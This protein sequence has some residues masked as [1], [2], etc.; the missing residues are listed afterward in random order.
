MDEIRRVI[1]PD[2]REV[3]FDVGTWLH[4]AD[5]RPWLLD[6]V[7]AVLAAVALPD[8]RAPDPAVG[9]ERFYARHPLL[10]ARWLRVI[11]DF[12]HEPAVVVTAMEDKVDPRSRR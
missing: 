2:G 11:V 7:G 8:H 12:E 4:L 3:V 6:H 10:P 1:D 5:R 9:R